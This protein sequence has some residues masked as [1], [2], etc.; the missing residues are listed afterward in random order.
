ME[1]E[2]LQVPGLKRP[3]K[4]QKHAYEEWKSS[5]LA[6]NETFKA[7]GEALLIMH[8][9]FIGNKLII[10]KVDNRYCYINVQDL[11]RKENK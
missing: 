6:S 4:M 10:L 3:K 1:F 2:P 8:W 9:C 5:V 7:T 11:K